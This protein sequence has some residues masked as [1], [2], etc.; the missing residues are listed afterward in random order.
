MLDP[1]RIFNCGGGLSRA[2]VRKSQPMMNISPSSPVPP[3]ANANPFGAGIGPAQ[4]QSRN[5]RAVDASPPLQNSVPGEMTGSEDKQVSLGQKPIA[6][7][8]PN[9]ESDVAKAVIY[10]AVTVT[11]PTASYTQQERLK[12]IDAY[13]G[14]VVTQIQNIESASEGESNIRFQKVRQFLEPAGYFSGGLLAAGYDPHEKVTVT[15]TSY[16]G[17]GR[18][19]ALTNTDKR[20]YFAWEIAAGALAH[21]KVQRGGPVNFQFM[22]IEKQDLTKVADLELQGKQLQKHWE[23]EIAT[24]MRDANGALSKRSGKADAYAV[25]GTLQHLSND[26]ESFEKLSLEGQEAIKRTLQKNGQVI[27]PNLYGYPLA[28]YAFIPNTPYDGK[29]EHR[30]N[31][32]VMVDLKNGTVHEITGDEA[33]AQW[34]KNNRSDLLRGFNAS[35]RQGRHDAHW[36]KAERLLDSFIEGTNAHY[37]GY[38]SFLKDKGVP[39]WE[40]FNYTESRATDYRLKYGDLNAGIATQ[41]QEVNAKNAVWSDQTEVFGSSQQNWKSA[42]DFW[43]NT[44]G[45]LPVVGNVGNVVF[46]VHDAIYG[47]TAD[48]RVGGSAAAV[49]SG[50]QLVHELAS[51]GVEVGLGERPAAATPL[52]YFWKHNPE[53][54]D[55][56]LV[57]VNNALKNTEAVSVP[58]EGAPKV[59][60]AADTSGGIG[61]MRE[62]EYAGQ[63]YFVSDKPDAGDGYFLLRVKDPHNPGKL[64]SSGKIAKPDNAGIW[65]RRGVAGGG[66]TEFVPLKEH[67]AGTTQQRPAA[68]EQILELNRRPSGR[69][70][71]TSQDPRDANPFIADGAYAFVIRADEPD[72]VYVGS[73][74]KGLTPQGKPYPYN[75]RTNPGW[76]EGHSALTSGLKSLKGGTTDVM[77]AGTVYIKDGQPEFW[78]NSSGHYTPSA[79]LRDTNLTPEVKNLLPAERFVDE[80][81]LT[82]AQRR[83]WDESTHLTPA[84]KEENDQFMLEQYSAQD[85]GSDD[86]DDDYD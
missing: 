61:Q 49:L 59:S 13:A 20:T 52:K 43:G 75:L 41:Y 36:P 69:Y 63:K 65:K 71:L 34:A 48:D 64:V 14:R 39:V 16:T 76:V 3:A 2:T 73:M 38:A 30:P 27:I 53:T 77:Y 58:L 19:E 74:N 9:H 51:I 81:D 54:N 37:P 29:P 7:P 23:N 44:F 40:T 83:L 12:R 4:G 42:K 18:S 56:E 31:Q 10:G 70:A 50:L 26:K 17:K 67:I 6:P 72:R 84:E 15:F 5:P 45:Y 33:F 85:S 1:A 82:P 11:P 22:E 8:A 47:M 35:D 32:G 57:R 60:P 28:G 78:T 24:P 46:G 68:P 66:R 21:D 80:D 55:F 86:S 79:E 25:R 62:V